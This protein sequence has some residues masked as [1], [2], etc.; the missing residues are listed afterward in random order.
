MA[1]KALWYARRTWYGNESA[2]RWS[3][4]AGD[5][6]YSAAGV[7]ISAYYSIGGDINDG[8]ATSN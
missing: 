5:F 2:H 1:S 3:I 6:E 8:I 7:S 4:P